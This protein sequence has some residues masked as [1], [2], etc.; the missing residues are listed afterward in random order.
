MAYLCQKCEGD[1]NKYF[2]FQTKADNMK[3]MIETNS[4]IYS[5]MVVPEEP[6]PAPPQAPP[7]PVMVQEQP[8]QEAI[9]P[10][11]LEEPEMGETHFTEKVFAAMVNKEL[12]IFAKEANS[13][14]LRAAIDE[15][16]HIDLTVMRNR[17]KE[18]V[19]ITWKILRTVGTTQSGKF[20]ETKV[21][22]ALSILLYSRSV[23]LNLFPTLI[24]MSLFQCG[25]KTRDGWFLTKL[26]I[27]V[28]SNLVTKRI[29][30]ALEDRDDDEV[31]PI[32]TSIPSMPY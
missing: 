31:G 25:L 22:T 13:G 2:E 16:P 10:E 19:P 24:A 1:L 11:D 17:L 12:T 28:S 8:T 5:S 21:L 9:V 32:V 7:Q 29:R 3:V 20:N 26:G 30:K 15:L 18:R 6:M 4:K 14:F 27:M 23:Q